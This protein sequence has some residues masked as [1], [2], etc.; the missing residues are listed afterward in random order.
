MMIKE[1]PRGPIPETW[2]ANPDWNQRTEAPEGGLQGKDRLI[3]LPEKE[4]DLQWGI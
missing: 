1:T 4:W 3:R 2:K